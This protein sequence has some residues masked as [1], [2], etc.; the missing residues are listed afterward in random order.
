MFFSLLSSF[1]PPLTSPPL[2]HSYSH[3]FFLPPSSLPSAYHEC[4]RISPCPP[5]PP[6]RAVKGATSAKG[7]TIHTASVTS[8]DA[9]P[10]ML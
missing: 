4:G 1:L 3:P 2:Y 7:T 10:R 8:Q 6:S 9:S 5:P